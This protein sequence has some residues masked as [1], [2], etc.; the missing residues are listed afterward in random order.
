MKP[1]RIGKADAGEFYYLDNLEMTGDLEA[2]FSD[3]GLKKYTFKSASFDDYFIIKE[4][5]E[6]N[7]ITLIFN[8]L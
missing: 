3:D 4:N 7:I 8:T 2:I 5:E 6:E 1:A